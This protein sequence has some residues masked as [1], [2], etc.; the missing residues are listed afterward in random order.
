[1]SPQPAAPLDAEPVI[2]RGLGIT[3]LTR[4]LVIVALVLFIPAL[5]FSVV[6]LDGLGSVMMFISIM[7]P[8]QRCLHDDHGGCSAPRPARASEELDQPIHREP[9][10]NT[11]PEPGPP[12]SLVKVTWH[13]ISTR[14]LI[15]THTSQ[16][17]ASPA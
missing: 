10:P 2:Y 3:A 12:P 14:T 1:M 11:A 17:S 4:V 13:G 7:M 9:P 6:I 16:H 8:G 15:Y 5:L